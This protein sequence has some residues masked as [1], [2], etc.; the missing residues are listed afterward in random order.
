MPNKLKHPVFQ[1]V[2]QI[3]E[4]NT[5][6]VYVIGGFVRDT[7]LGKE[8]KD[9]DIVVV[10][11]GIELAEAVATR[12]DKATKVTIFKTFGTAQLKWKGYH[13]EFVG[14]R[15]ESYRKDSRKPVVENGTLEDDQLRRDF[16]I[17]TLAYSLNK[18]DYGN[19]IDPFQGVD[20]LNN[21]I[22][23]TPLEPGVTFSDDPLRMLRAIRF[24]TQ[25]D[26]RIEEKTFEAIQQ[27]AERIKIIS[28]ERVS[29]E[30]NK[31]ILSSKPSFGF[32]LLEK[33]SLLSYI[34]PELQN[35][36][37]VNPKN[38]L[39]HKDNFYHTLKVLDNLTEMSD[40]I[41]L[42]WAALLHDIGKPETKR[43]TEETGWTFHGHEIVGAK[44]IPEI[45]RK[46]KLPLNEKMK[47]VQTLVLLHLRPI[48]LSKE[49]ITDSAIRRLLF[50][51]GDHLE[52]LM[53]MCEA[54]IT[55]KNPETVKKHLRNFKI[56]RKKLR[57]IEEKDTIRNFQ[58][59]ISGDL[60]IETF[61]I[62][63]GREVGMIKNAIKEAILDG[64]IKNDF[65][66][67]F[68]LMLKM[69]EDLG[70]KRKK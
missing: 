4:E 2:S 24:A 50:D 64:V 67:A 13:I 12:L 6:P 27:S 70:L 26:F 17:N 19:L 29:D 21:R 32:K 9:I 59:P 61:E 5:T 45:F 11:S 69:G 62:I 25:L 36:K 31:I 52:D 53:L 47:Y 1:I 60:I 14:A 66:Q 56:V 57:E 3:A 35:M 43:F 37:G 49:E 48:I 58:P 15:K 42:R 16:T 28:M 22:I 7:L 38:G 55:S 54:D 18:V 63:P 39:K 10:G 30:L 40:N 46:L 65:Q 33:S 20:D 44:M 8:S 34:F 41:W 68:D 23:K 51:A